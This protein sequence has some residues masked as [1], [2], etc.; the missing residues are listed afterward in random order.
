MLLED[1]VLKGLEDFR[2]IVVEVGD[3]DNQ[4]ALREAAGEAVEGRGDGRPPPGRDALEVPEHA[5]QVRGGRARRQMEADLL[6]EGDHADHVLLAAH[7]VG[8][9]RG[10]EATVVELRLAAAQAVVHRGAGVQED[11]GA[12]VGLLLV[13]LDVVAVAA[14]PGDPVEVPHVVAGDVLAMLGEL[15]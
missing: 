6:V 11:V 7:E 8:Q 13:L 14:A 15:D 1:E 12:E 5:V 10:Q 4:S 3:D 2:R 9:A